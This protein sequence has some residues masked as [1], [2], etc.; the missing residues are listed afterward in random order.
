MP[1]ATSSPGTTTVWT[2]THS[3]RPGGA[4][5]T[6]VGQH[7]ATAVSASRPRSRAAAERLRRP[8]HHPAL[9][10]SESASD[11][12][13]HPAPALRVS[14][15]RGLGAY[16]NVFAIESFMDELA[17]E[18]GIDPVAFRLQASRPIRARSMW[19]SSRPRISA[20]MP[21]QSCPRAAAAALRSRDTRTSPAIAR[22]RSSSRSSTRPAH[23]PHPRGR[24]PPTAAR[25][26]IRTASRTRSKAA[27][28][29]RRAGRC[30]RRWRSTARASLSRD[31]SSYPILRFP[32]M[33]ESVDVHVIDRPGPAVPRHR[34][35]EPGP[36]RG[37]HRQRGGERDG[38]N[39]Y[40][41]CRLRAQG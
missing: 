4:G 20:G 22:S 26:S 10:D 13:L 5:A 33:F 21:A 17:A 29:S 23:P 15:L 19:S 37:R 30:T 39:G 28:C 7:I 35:S 27:S 12:Q 32:E 6:L 31:W 3:T 34:R 40:A 11:L 8:Q 36:D 14:A 25:P 2:D 38:R 18:A 24:R 16:A 9:P 1:T 41:S